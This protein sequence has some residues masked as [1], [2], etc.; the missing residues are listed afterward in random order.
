MRKFRL[1]LL[2]LLIPITVFA[3]AVPKT[4]VALLGHVT[5]RVS[6]DPVVVTGYKFYVSKTIGTY[7]ATPSAT[8]V[9]G[10]AEITVLLSNVIPAP[11]SGNYYIVATSY[12]ATEESIYSNPVPVYAMGDGT[13]FIAAPLGAPGAL[14]LR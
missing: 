8:V 13:Y 4:Q 14:Q 12:T 3:A 10:V 5:E 11:A 6:G 7:P 9:E 2:L 1:F